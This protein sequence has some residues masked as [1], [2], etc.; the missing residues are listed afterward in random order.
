MNTL[1]FLVKSSSGFVDAFV[2]IL[3]FVNFSWLFSDIICNSAQQRKNRCLFLNALK[4]Y[5][6][7]CGGD[8]SMNDTRD[9]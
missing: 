5:V 6:D 1:M 9:L 8:K 3:L 2:F 7:A 4:R